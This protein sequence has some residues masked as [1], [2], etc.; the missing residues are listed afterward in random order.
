MADPVVIALLG[1]QGTGK[2]TLAAGLARRLEAETGL[3]CT[4]VVE[5][6]RA[7]YAGEGRAPRVNEQAAIARE[8]H[9][10]IATAA[11]SHDV[12]VCDTT[13]LADAVHRRLDSGDASLEACAVE[14]HRDQ[15]QLSL[16][17]ALD[18]PWTARGPR[19]EGEPQRELVDDALRRLLQ[20]HRL[21]WVAV[22]GLGPRR[23]EAA[24]DA[25]APMLRRRELPRPGLFTRLARREAA[26]R[27]WIWACDKCDQPDCEHASR[28]PP[29]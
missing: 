1:A 22:A 21:P 9:R 4:W 18:L 27:P 17:T 8:H 20:A 10:R 12:V 29:A 26:A 23:E 7:G 19:E 3:R 15:V 11:A 24:L 6:R 25:V 28:R 16:L 14:L 13:A 2:T 5:G